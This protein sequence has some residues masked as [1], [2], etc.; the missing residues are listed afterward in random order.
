MLS[1]DLTRILN[2]E[3]MGQEHAVR[4]IVRS[5]LLSL[6]WPRATTRPIGLFLLLGPPGTGKRRLPYALSRALYGNPQ[7]V[8][9]VNVS[10]VTDGSAF[11]DLVLARCA[12][13]PG[14]PGALALS[15]ILPNTWWTRAVIVVEELEKAVPGIL[16]QLSQAA[17]VGFLTGHAG[18][19][20]VRRAFFILKSELASEQITDLIDRSGFGFRMASAEDQVNTEIERITTRA[21]TAQFHP[22]FLNH[23]DGIIVLRRIKAELLEPILDRFLAEVRLRVRAFGAP[24]TGIVLTQDAREL[25]LSRARESLHLGYRPLR[26]LVEDLVEF[27]LLDLA[28]AGFI[29][30]P[31][32]ILVDVQGDVLH[33]SI[34]GEPGTS[35]FAMESLS[36]PLP[37]SLNPAA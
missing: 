20:D 23:L 33:F 27:P 36:V 29:T 37:L 24:V 9:P 7:M 4:A 2:H 30:L 17:D 25:L 15:P 34:P 13:V 26:R 32:P 28:I 5:V 35:P 12:A 16:T 21:I 14:P 8:A 31:G 22:E 19:L 18:R 11:A 6:S 10:G 3:L 1:D